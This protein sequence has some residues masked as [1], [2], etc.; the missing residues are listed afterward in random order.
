MTAMGVTDPP[1]LRAAVAEEVRVLLTRRRLSGAKLADA[2]GRSQAYV[3]RRL[4][5]ETAFDLDDLERI[6][7]ILQVSVS[8]LLPRSGGGPI[9][10]LAQAQSVRP[11][12]N[13]PGGRL[14]ATSGPGRATRTHPPMAA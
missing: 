14:S 11:G 6:A 13:R 10:W 7:A 8:E 9:A 12:D 2:I 3:W 5:G 4:S 1:A